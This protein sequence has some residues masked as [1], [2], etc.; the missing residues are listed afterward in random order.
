MSS[1]TLDDYVSE[2]IRQ[3]LHYIET[4]YDYRPQYTPEQ[5]KRKS[6]ARKAKQTY[7]KKKA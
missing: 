7:K 6:N 1:H 3:R 5:L 4:E 2:T